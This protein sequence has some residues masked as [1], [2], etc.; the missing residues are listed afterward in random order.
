MPLG[1]QMVLL[2]LAGVLAAERGPTSAATGSNEMVRIR[3]EVRAARKDWR[4]MLKDLR[5]TDP[6]RARFYELG[7]LGEKQVDAGKLDEAE[8]SAKVLLTVA[9]QFQC[10]WNY[11]NAI[12]RAHIVLGR[13]ALARGDRET[14]KA[15]LVEA[16]QTPSSP[17]LASAG[18]DMRLARALLLEGERDAVLQYFQVCAKFWELGR[19]DLKE[20]RD[21]VE[22]GTV[23]E[24]RRTMR[25]C[26]GRRWRDAA[27]PP[28][29]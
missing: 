29:R 11:G 26:S 15:R 3:R 20:W 25:T 22:A 19:C 16:G 6:D 12:H 24:F 21:A 13:V 2:L 7:D 9:Q 10:D 18:P 5:N 27:E 23:P 1:L 8:A 17:Q 4:A 14:A 28:M